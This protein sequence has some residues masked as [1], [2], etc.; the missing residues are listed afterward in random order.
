[1]DPAKLI[2]LGEWICE[3]DCISGVDSWLLVDAIPSVPV[4]F[5][6]G[7]VVERRPNP[8]WWILLLPAGPFR[9]IG[10]CRETVKVKAGDG[11]LITG[12]DDI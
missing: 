7:G 8:D 1:M 11:A 2:R 5:E 6:T 10:K 3:T 9:R 4:L 12:A